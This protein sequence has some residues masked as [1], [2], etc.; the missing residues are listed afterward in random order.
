LKDGTKQNKGPSKA[1]PKVA[2]GIKK[3]KKSKSGGEKKRGITQ[4][5]NKT[6]KI[7]KERKQGILRNKKRCSAC[8]NRG[9]SQRKGDQMW[10]GDSKAF[11]VPESKVK[12]KERSRK[13]GPC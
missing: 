7:K 4:S 11:K 1:K 9:E 13:S 10:R 6:K 8:G 12:E 2:K 5:K 3:E